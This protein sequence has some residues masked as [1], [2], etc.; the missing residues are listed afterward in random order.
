MLYKIYGNWDIKIQNAKKG[1][2]MMRERLYQ[3]KVLL[4]LDDV[5]KMEQLQATIAGSSDWFGPGSRVIIT[6]RDKHLLVSHGVE[7]TYEV[8]K[9]SE[10][11]ALELFCWNA[12][13][14]N[15]VDPSYA[16]ISKQALAFASGHPL[17][18]QVVG[19]CL[20]GRSI[21]EWSSVLDTVERIPIKQIQTVLKISY[22]SL[23]EEEKRIFL[24]IACFFNGEKLEVVEDILLSLYGASVNYSIEELI[25]K[26]LIKI[27]DGFV[28]LH[29]LIQD[30]G[31]EIVRQESPL[32]PGKRSRLWF[33][34][35][36]VHVLQENSVS[37]KT[38]TRWFDFLFVSFIF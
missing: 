29:N 18:L 23:E 1:I 30:M 35:D 7:R 26:S 9:L 2:S 31:R 19:S 37:N 13:K 21:Y 22:D 14:T 34:Q 11:E 28:T 4:V 27:D 32:E 24:D 17:A 33:P 6:T 5:D 20:F 3:K 15:K 16:D 12:F 10:K 38:D 36:V 25:E 8:E